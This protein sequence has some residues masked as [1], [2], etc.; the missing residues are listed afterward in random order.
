MIRVF[1]GYDHVEEIAFHTCVSSIIR[2]ATQPVAITPVSLQSLGGLMTRPRDP[3]QSNEFSF[4]RFLVPHLCEYQG[5]AIFMDCDIVLTAD[6]AKLWD[7]RNPEYAIQ[8]CQHDYVPRDSVKYLGNA[9]LA[10]PRKNW[11]SVM[12]FNNRRCKALTP[13]YVNT[14]SGLALHRFQWLR[15]EAIG[16]LPLEW[17]WLVGE[18]PENSGAAAYH[19]TV[20]GPWFREYEGTDHASIWFEQKEYAFNSCQREDK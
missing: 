18:Y 4:S 19:F 15:D 6:I 2:H 9:Q 5:W 11:S 20:G 14:A 10:Y 17:N 12:L 8:V 3:R 1:I 7:L 13:N 16:A